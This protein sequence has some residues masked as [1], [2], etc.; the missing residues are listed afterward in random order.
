MSGTESVTDFEIQHLL[1]D[2][3]AANEAWLAGTASG[4]AE[5][6]MYVS[7]LIETAT[8]LLAERQRLAHLA[9]ECDVE[10]CPSCA[11]IRE[12]VEALNKE[13]DSRGTS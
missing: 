4:P 1:S 3:R 7:N 11:A 2:A 9:Y 6:S 5:L 13:H 8:S 12:A 10:M